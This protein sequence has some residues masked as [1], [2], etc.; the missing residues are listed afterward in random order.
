MQSN[1]FFGV[2][3]ANIKSAQTRVVGRKQRLNVR[4]PTR[5][6][7]LSLPSNELRQLLVE[8]MTHSAT[9]II[10]SRAQ[11]YEVLTVL[12]TR[13]DFSEIQDVAEMCA[14]YIIGD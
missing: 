9:E 13:G 7:V 2:H 3:L 14:N 5:K 8:W 1:Q 12:R 6:E 10:P 11:I 4:V